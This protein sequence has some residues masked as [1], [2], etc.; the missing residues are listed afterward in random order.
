MQLSSLVFA[1]G[2][3]GKHLCASDPASAS[4]PS[5]R[6]NASQREARQCQVHPLH[7][8]QYWLRVAQNPTHQLPI[9]FRRW[10]HLL[11]T[12]DVCIPDAEVLLSSLL[13]YESLEMAPATPSQSTV[14]PLHPLSPHLATRSFNGG[15]HL[16]QTCPLHV[17]LVVT[18]TT[19]H[20]QVAVS[21]LV[22]APIGFWGFAPTSSPHPP[23]PPVSAAL[24]S[25]HSPSFLSHFFPHTPR[26]QFPPPTHPHNSFPLTVLVHQPCRS[27]RCARFHP[28]A[29]GFGGGG[30][31]K[32]RGGGILR[33]AR[34]ALSSRQRFT[35][36]MLMTLDA[37]RLSCFVQEKSSHGLPG[38]RKARNRHSIKRS[39]YSSVETGFSKKT[40]SP[41][42]YDN[43]HFLF[44]MIKIAI[45]QM[46][47]IYKNADVVNK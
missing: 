5:S 43:L 6:A 12:K 23:T 39:R 42:P 38:F 18:R 1:L 35:P 24:S 40:L 14:V 2:V 47:T 30:F 44:E 33:H 17:S 26:S 4:P 46:A 8:D 3:Q 45:P 9:D 34:S 16:V 15:L 13:G 27:S 31:R 41:F 20:L 29:V 19:N 37:T 10:M 25:S 22:V 36:I 28:V 11:Y 21:V 32:R 7:Y